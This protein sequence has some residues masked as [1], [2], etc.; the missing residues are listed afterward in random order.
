VSVETLQEDL[1]ANLAGLRDLNALSSVDDVVK[2][3]K[4]SLWPFLESAVEQMEDLDGCIEDL[5]NNHEDILQPETGE[6]F[7]TVVTSALILIGELK[8][9]LG[10]GDDPRIAASIAEFERNA[11]QMIGTLQEIT[12]PEIDDD[13]EDVDADEDADEDDADEAEGDA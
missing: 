9:R 5:L 2:H 11:N 3:L 6:L 4:N 7:T 1:K 10:P 12:I 8:K 13:D